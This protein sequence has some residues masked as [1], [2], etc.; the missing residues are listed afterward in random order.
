M[1]AGAVGA[2]IIFATHF[3]CGSLGRGATLVRLAF[4]HLGLGLRL[5]GHSL[6]LAN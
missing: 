5:A 4:A 6:S 1:K 2:S 3:F